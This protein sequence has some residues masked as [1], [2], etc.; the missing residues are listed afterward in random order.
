MLTGEAVTV[1]YESVSC[2][3]SSNEKFLLIFRELAELAWA[4]LKL[5]MNDGNST[6][7]EQA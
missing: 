1:A 3:Y 6:S 4:T 2:S 7:Y 5:L